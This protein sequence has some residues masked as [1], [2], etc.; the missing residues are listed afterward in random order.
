MSCMTNRLLTKLLQP[1]RF[2]HHP[3]ATSYV[4]ADAMADHVGLP[5]SLS[6]GATQSG[7]SSADLDQ[8]ILDVANDEREQRLTAAR[9]CR[10]Q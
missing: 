4:D 7:L 8:F 2:N 3:T 9:D 10:K 6:V 1:P 5:S